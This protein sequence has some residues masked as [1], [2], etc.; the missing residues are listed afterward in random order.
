M[1][2]ILMVIAVLFIVFCFSQPFLFAMLYTV[3][4]IIGLF[5]VFALV[6]YIIVSE[7]TE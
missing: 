3:L 1:N 6:G 7:F 5:I 2:I 4:S